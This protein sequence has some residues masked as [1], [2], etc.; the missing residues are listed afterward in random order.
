[1]ARTPRSTSGRKAGPKQP[2]SAPAGR[3]PKPRQAARDT[4]V[5]AAAA[6]GLQPPPRA[7]SQRIVLTGA[8]GFI[9]GAIARLL[10]E[11]GDAVVGLV[12]DRR[13][14]AHL[15]DLGVEIIEDDLA[16]IDRLAEAFRGADAVI[17][18]AGMYR[19]GIPRSDRGPMWDANVGTT[20]RVLNA[21]EGAGTPRIVY[22]STVNVFGNTHGRVVDESYRRD[23][24]EGFVS[25]YDETKYGAHEVVEQRVRDGAPI[26]IALP[27]Q[28]YGPRDHSEIGERL[29]AAYEGSLRYAALD[30]VGF[31]LVHV[32]DLAAGVVA[33]L[34][35]GQPGRAYVLSGPTTTLGDAIGIAA[36]IGGRKPPMVRVP[37]AALSLVASL[38]SVIGRPNLREVIAASAGVTY[39]ASAGRAREELGW[40]PRDVETGLR[41]TFG[42]AAGSAGSA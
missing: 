34:D 12:R 4:P 26:V 40:E 16:E 41:D 35:R 13:R 32:D 7:A 14:A 10:R 33:A 37:T 2:A 9:G 18:A 30:D 20:T 31:G 25:W 42:A 36:R 15:D 23:L 3:T 11:R 38:G 19:I 1:L 28:V 29:R 21:A 27:S 39:W 6:D 5:V 24:A 22:V 17:H 8:A